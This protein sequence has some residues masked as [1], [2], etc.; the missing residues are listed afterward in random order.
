MNTLYLV[1]KL[2]LNKHKRYTYVYITQTHIYT[3]NHV[4]T[5]TNHTRQIIS[6]YSPTV[7]LFWICRCNNFMC[8]VGSAY[9]MLK[10]L[11]AASRGTSAHSTRS[12]RSDTNDARISGSREASSPFFRRLSH[13]LRNSHG[14]T[15]LVPETLCR[16]HTIVD[17]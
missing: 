7:W 8:H 3:C 11:V 15:I 12:A 16:N 17:S 4:C 9:S 6:T 1:Y 10:V 5:Y 13:L 2:H 14:E